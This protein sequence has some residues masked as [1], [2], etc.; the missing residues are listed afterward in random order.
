MY[1]CEKYEV[2]KA[3]KYKH[4][5]VTL[6][7]FKTLE[8]TSSAI[9]KQD[10]DI[11]SFLKDVLNFANNEIEK[12]EFSYNLSLKQVIKEVKTFDFLENTL[13]E[14][15]KMLFDVLSD[16]EMQIIEPEYKRFTNNLESIRADL[17]TCGELE[18]WKL[19][20]QSEA[21]N[22]LDNEN[23]I[24]SMPVLS[25]DWDSEEDKQWDTKI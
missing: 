25:E 22:D 14:V 3:K 24:A 15:F 11:L 7:L 8:K 21:L 19:D 9:V 4:N 2:V 20:E 18:A 16:N 5:I 12:Q 23:Y 17:Q 13:S 1:L 10:T 6:I